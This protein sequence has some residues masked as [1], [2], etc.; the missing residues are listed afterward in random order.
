MNNNNKKVML[1]GNK[2]ENI[3]SKVTSSK[4]TL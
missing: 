3:R 4:Y 2:E 1:I